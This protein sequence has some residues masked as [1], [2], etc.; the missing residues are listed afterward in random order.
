MSGGLPDG[1]QTSNNQLLTKINNLTEC[2]SQLHGAVKRIQYLQL[3]TVALVVVLGA[4]VSYIIHLENREG[5]SGS[6]R[7]P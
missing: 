6:C 7:A 2:Q 1:D 4:L 3:A 5:F